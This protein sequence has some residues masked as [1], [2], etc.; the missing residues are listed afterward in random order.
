MIQDIHNLSR[1]CW[2]AIDLSEMGRISMLEVIFKCLFIYYYRNGAN[3]HEEASPILNGATET[4]CAK[5]KKK[6]KKNKE[7]AV[8]E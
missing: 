5:K 8:A 1:I 4:E 2:Y 3:G 6:K 7:A